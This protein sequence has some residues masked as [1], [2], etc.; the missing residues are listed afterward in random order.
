M[1]DEVLAADRDLFRDTVEEHL[2][3]EIYTIRQWV[4]SHKSTIFNKAAESHSAAP[5]Q[6]QKLLPSC[7]HPLKKGKQKRN[8]ICS[9]PTPVPV[10][11]STCMGDHFLQF[12]LPLTYIPRSNKKLAHLVRNFQQLPL[13]F[14]GDHPT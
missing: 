14:G 3:D 8:H 12:P 4:L 5:R 10:Y 11:Q 7:F 1:R 2:T 13:I 6:K 9:D